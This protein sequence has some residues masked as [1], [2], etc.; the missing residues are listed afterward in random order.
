MYFHYNGW[1]F[2]AAGTAFEKL[3]G[4]NIDDAIQS[5]LAEPIGMQDFERSAQRKIPHEGQVHPEYAMYLST[6][7]MA[8]IGL[9]MLRN[10]NWDGKQPDGVGSGNPHES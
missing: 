2:N 7:D 4:K 3:T 1:D 9:L 6:R 5:E 10:G 8:R